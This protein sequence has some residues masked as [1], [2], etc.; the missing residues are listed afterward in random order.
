MTCDTMGAV[1][2]LHGSPVPDHQRVTSGVP[3]ADMS[4]DAGVDLGLQCRKQPRRAPSRT[5][6]SR[7]SSS[8]GRS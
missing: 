4:L 2:L 7:S 6:A 3:L 1:L 5:S 8:P